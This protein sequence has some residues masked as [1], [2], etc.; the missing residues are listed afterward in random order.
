ML[1]EV[2]SANSIFFVFMLEKV[3]HHD[4]ILFIQKIKKKKVE[5]K[6]ST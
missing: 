5:E 3:N 6:R 2:V 4:T 1:H